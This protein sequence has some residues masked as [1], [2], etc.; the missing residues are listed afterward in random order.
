MNGLTVVSVDGAHHVIVLVS[1]LNSAELTRLAQAVSLPLAQRLEVSL[2]RDE[3][4]FASLQ[5]ADPLQSLMLNSAV[6]VET[7]AAPM[8]YSLRST[9]IGSTREARR[10]GR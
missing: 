2:G 10:A 5:F 1:D 6:A 9:T 7:R 4:S 3:G 8:V